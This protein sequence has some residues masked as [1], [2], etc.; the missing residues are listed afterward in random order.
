M[1]KTPSVAHFNLTMIIWEVKVNS[2]ERLKIESRSKL[3]DNNGWHFKEDMK[4]LMMAESFSLQTHAHIFVSWAITP[5]SVE[6]H[7][8][9]LS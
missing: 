7:P 3:N 4:V 6:C 9:P 2:R 1:K 8:P 5:L